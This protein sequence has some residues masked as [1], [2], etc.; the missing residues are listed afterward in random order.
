MTLPLIRLL[1]QSG[2][3]ERT[4]IVALVSSPSHESRAALL[5]W[6]DRTGS[7]EYA[8]EKAQS[9]AQSAAA[10]LAALPADNAA[11]QTLR[12]LTEF[13]VNRPS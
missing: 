9:F 11:A 3:A 1:E 12:M 8:R 13:V 4:E 7:L 5:E 10:A 2:E 6:L